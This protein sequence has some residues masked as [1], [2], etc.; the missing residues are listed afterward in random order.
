MTAIT[1]TRTA[2][3]VE[4]WRPVLRWW[5]LS[6]LITLAA[7]G[8]L[9]L[10]GPRGSLGPQFYG[11]PLELL[12]SW[13][14]VWYSRIAQHGYLLVP[15]M[16]SD[17][18]FFPLYPLILHAW[19]AVG[20]PPHVSGPIVSNL[21]LAVAL[22]AFYELGRRVV[23]ERV[24]LRAT[25]FAAVAPMSLVYSMTY[26]MSLLFALGALAVL[27]AYED[28]WLAAT[29]CAAGAGLT[30]PE[31]I[32][33]ALPIAQRAWARRHALGE[34]RRGAAAAAVFAAPLAVATYP[35]YLEWAL[36]DVHAWSQAERRWGRSFGITGPVHAIVHVPALISGHPGLARDVALFVVYAALLVVAARTGIGR[37]WI[38]AGAAVIVLPL[39]SGTFESEGRFGL[40][41]FPVY[42]ALAIIART[43]RRERAVIVGS[44]SLLGAAVAGLPYIWP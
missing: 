30:R 33:F 21:A 27:F 38:A 11:R 5:A 34:E 1:A 17:T 24:A 8:V 36:G 12:S 18:A 7:F 10:F 9:E 23:G 20:V 15:G 25:I 19:N 42:W 41:A 16:Q 26:P 13:D 39:F 29:I 43:R 32:V 37:A 14:G 35:L 4:R 6:R 22:I 2:V 31:A 40:I 3:L 44:I 28:R